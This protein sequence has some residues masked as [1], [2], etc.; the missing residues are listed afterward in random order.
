M[1]IDAQI[2]RVESMAGGKASL[3]L[4]TRFARLELSGCGCGKSGVDGNGA[5][6][7]GLF[8]SWHL[9]GWTFGVYLR[10][11]FFDLLSFFVSYL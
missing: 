8:Q 4:D 5:I 1:S 10:D 3:V 2:G 7:A 9:V 6:S 11:G